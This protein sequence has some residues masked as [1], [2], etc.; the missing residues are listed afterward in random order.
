M[1]YL[2]SIVASSLWLDGS[3]HSA[4]STSN[5]NTTRLETY[6]HEHSESGAKKRDAGN[7]PLEF[8]KKPSLRRTAFDLELG[9]SISES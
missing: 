8:L 3:A 2:N 6:R 4:D 1:E 7:A 9:Q 5:Q